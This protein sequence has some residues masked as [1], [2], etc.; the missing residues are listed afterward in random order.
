MPKV[1]IAKIRLYLKTGKTLS[2]GSS[3]IMLMCSFN[4]RKEVSTGYSCIQKYWDERGQCVKKGYP[5]WLMINSMIKKMKDDAIAIRDDYER[6]GESYTPSM[7]LSPRKSLSAVTNDLKG[8][9]GR[10]ISEKGL[11]SRSIEKWWIVY[12]NVT[13]FYGREVIVNEIDESFCRRYG[14]WME[15]NGLSAGSIRS[16]LAKIG[17]I[18]HYAISLG[19]ISKHPFEAWKYHKEYRD[20]KSEL[21]IHHSSMD[22]MLDIFLSRVIDREGNLWNYK[23]GVIEELMDIHS[24]LYG[25][26][27]YCSIYVM[28]G[29]S[30]VDISLL[31]KS[32]IRIIE[33]KGITCYAIDGNRS[34]TGMP[35]KIR[36]RCDEVINQVIIGVM[37]MFN[38]GEYFLPSLNGFSGDIKKRV[39]N[40]YTYHGKHLV[41]WFRVVNEEI[42][43]RNVENCLSIPLIDLECRYYS[44][45][46]SFIMK[47]IQKPNVNL[48]RIATITGK[49]VKTLHQYISLLNDI[50][51]ID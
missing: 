28:G 44:A 5:N 9:I 41:D 2:D 38:Q 7:I 49:S 3:P 10:Y 6:L 11:G 8:L 48:I 19:L 32:D 30:P 12:R 46:H 21:Y 34:K 14:R 36:L 33:L 23:E 40:L 4:G 29:I 13:K 37:L 47:E 42:V 26:Y 39:N 31:K 18:C 17:A 35:Y 20:S 1:T 15:G 51:L 50:D 22:V 24:E 43:R 27:L 16:Y 45:R 25:L